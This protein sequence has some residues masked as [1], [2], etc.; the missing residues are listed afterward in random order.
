M[1]KIIFKNKKYYLNIF[2]SE[3]HFEK[4]PLLYSETP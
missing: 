2:S 3:K 1:S 4:Q